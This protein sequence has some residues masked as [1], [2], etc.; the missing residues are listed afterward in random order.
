MNNE[1]LINRLAGLMI[2]RGNSHV[3]NGP[4][5]EDIILNGDRHSQEHA[6]AR[7][8]AYV[9]NKFHQENM[10]HRMRKQ[11]SH[12]SPSIIGHVHF[13]ERDHERPSLPSPP[14]GTSSTKVSSAPELGTKSR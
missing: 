7:W 9:Q 4:I 8:E 12:S 14:I 10:A 6:Q 5:R 1:A 13:D 2:D 3:E 11:S